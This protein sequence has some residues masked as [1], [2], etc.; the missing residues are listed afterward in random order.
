MAILK[1]RYETQ[2]EIPA[3]FEELYEER[4]KDDEGGGAWLLKRDAIEG[5]KTEADVQRVQRALTKATADKKELKAKLDAFGD[6]DPEQATKDLDELEELR[7]KIEAGEGG[8]DDGRREEVIQRRIEA[9]LKPWKRKVDALESERDEY[10]TKHEEVVTQRMADRREAHLRKAAAA[11]GLRNEAIE[12]AILYAGHFE[13]N[14][15]GKFVTREGV[16]DVT[17]GLDPEV[18]FSDMKD[19]RPHWWPQS[20]GGGAQ[21]NNGGTAGASNPFSK[22]AWNKTEQGRLAAADPGKAE[23]FAKRAGFKTLEQAEAAIRPPA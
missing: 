18:W 6:L 2:D 13:E 1:A 5:V 23:Q 14:D 7:A 22:A 9:A 12:D 10:K 17:P 3:G 21:G 15:E 19:R 8:D 20:Q 16:P 4:G 11:A